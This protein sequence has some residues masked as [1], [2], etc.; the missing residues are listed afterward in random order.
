LRVLGL[1]ILLVTT[2]K[3]FLFDMATLEG[4]VRAASFL[5]LGAVL[6]FGAFTARRLRGR[7]LPTTPKTP[8]TTP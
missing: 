2:A 6:L 3:V 1:T 4:V 7:P 5:A 8:K